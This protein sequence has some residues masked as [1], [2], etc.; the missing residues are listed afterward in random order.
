MLEFISENRDGGTIVVLLRM[1]LLLH[2][3][4][5]RATRIIGAV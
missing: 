1:L 5:A 2:L 4:C 3:D